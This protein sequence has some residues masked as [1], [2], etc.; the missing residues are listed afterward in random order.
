MRKRTKSRELA[1]QLLYQTEIS[2]DKEETQIRE[3][4]ARAKESQSGDEKFDEIKAFT[5]RLV[6]LIEEHQ[7]DIDKAIT[8]SAEHWEMSRMAVVDKNILRIGTCE[9]LYCPDIPAKVAIN[10]SIELAKKFGDQETSKFVN[11]ILD[12]VAKKYAHEV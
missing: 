4:W 3:F 10:E 5:T 9:I 11:G 1:L 7:S 12:Q 6:Q 8:S 2:K